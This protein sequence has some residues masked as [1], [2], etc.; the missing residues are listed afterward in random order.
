MEKDKIMRAAM[1][2]GY[3]P[4]KDNTVSLRFVTQEMTPYE[5]AHIHGLRESFGYLMF[6][7]EKM[8]T[9]QEIKAIE[10]MDTEITGKTKSKEYMNVLYVL[11]TQDGQG[12]EKFEDFYRWWMND[13]IQ[14][15]KD[16]LI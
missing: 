9:A 14:E 3:T 8:L 5:V 13:R 6:K 4:R 7:S 16:Q 11:W 10:E 15:V 2:D 1:F 12:Y